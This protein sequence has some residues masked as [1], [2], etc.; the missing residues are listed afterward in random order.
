[1][2]ITDLLHSLFYFIFIR[3]PAMLRQILRPWEQVIQ[4]RQVC[5]IQVFRYL[6]QEMLHIFIDFY[7]ICFCGF[8][9][10]VDDCT[11]FRSTDSV[12]KTPVVFPDTEP[13]KGGFCCV[14]IH[15]DF[16]IIQKYAQVCFLVYGIDE[17]LP[18]LGFWRHFTLMFFCPCKISIHQRLY[19]H[20]PPVLPFL[21]LQTLQFMI[22]FI[23]CPDLLYGIIR[24]CA[25]SLVLIFYGFQG[26][27]VFASCMRLIRE[28]E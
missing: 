19:F 11:G 26:I 24:K 27:R 5:V 25:F 12:Y 18:G 20:L 22:K 9:D 13:T 16:A 3:F 17:R 1:M 2:I 21:W 4:E 14:V 28:L 7:P 10:A 15:W 23:D 8:R 6:C